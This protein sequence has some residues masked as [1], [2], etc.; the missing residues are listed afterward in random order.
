MAAAKYIDGKLSRLRTGFA[1][2]EIGRVG[3]NDE[4]PI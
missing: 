4:V 1:H 2:V 3:E